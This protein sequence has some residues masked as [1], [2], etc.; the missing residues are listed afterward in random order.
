MLWWQVP[1]YR[2]AYSY[3]INFI[4]TTTNPIITTFTAHLTCTLFLPL[5][6]L[7]NPLLL[8][9]RPRVSPAKVSALIVRRCWGNT[10]NSSRIEV[11]RHTKSH[12]ESFCRGTQGINTC[13]FFTLLGCSTN[14]ILAAPEWKMTKLFQPTEMHLSVWVAAIRNFFVSENIENWSTFFF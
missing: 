2:D 6:S 10:F 8:T 9:L 7:W 13:F 3:V 1:T 12:D 14:Q 5:H 11:D 4:I